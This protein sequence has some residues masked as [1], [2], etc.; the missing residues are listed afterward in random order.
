VTFCT[1][2]AVQIPGVAMRRV[3]SHPRLAI[4]GAALAL[5]VALLGFGAMSS[6]SAA[7]F[8][9]NSLD[10]T[11]GSGGAVTVST[12]VTSASTVTAAY[13][14]V[15]VRS[16]SGANLDYPKR[17]N[18][19][20]TAGAAQGF[21]ATKTFAVG[22][23]S[24]FACLYSGGWVNVGAAK[25]FTVGSTPPPTTSS[26]PPPTS[27][28]SSPPPTSTSSSPPPTGTGT[29]PH[30]PA[31]NWVQTFDDEFNGTAVDTTKW[32]KNWYGEGG[33]M[34]NVG[35]YAADVTESGGSLNLALPDSTHGALVHTDIPGGYRLPV[36]SCV[37]AEVNFPGSGSTIYNWPAWWASSAAADGWPS[38]GEH[39]IAEGLGPLTI[40]YHSPSGAHNFGAVAGTW[41]GA[42]HDYTLCR[43]AG[44][45]DVYWDG[46]LRKHY[47]TDDNG[48]PEILI[49]NVGVGNTHVYGAAA[50][51]H[52]N[53]V[54][55]FKPGP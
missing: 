35:T 53:Y 7:T 36:G 32:A 6:A 44:S 34:N 1:F 3:R 22:T 43:N 8:T 50:T 19:V 28:S 24:Y 39:D 12:S 18:V 27:T 15:C 11:V 30:G 13:Y 26:S 14:G 23:Y 42:Y 49:L 37:E 54:R 25:S 55:A 45:A 38:S 9:L 40:N 46:V 33:K 51:V 20:F 17:T 41:A 21:A 2:S 29:G 4:L 47:T 48:K 10:A 31:G 52:V 5:L 16:S